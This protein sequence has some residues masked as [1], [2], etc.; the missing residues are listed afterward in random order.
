MD[1]N[2]I[3]NALYDL[4]FTAS[5]NMRYYALLR[6]TYTHL[7]QTWFMVGVGVALLAAIVLL[8][9]RRRGYGVIDTIGVVGIVLV[10]VCVY[11]TAYYAN[12]ADMTSPHYR[13]WQ[14]HYHDVEQVYFRARIAD[15][16]TQMDSIEYMLKLLHEGELLQHAADGIATDTDLLLQA[17]NDELQARTGFKSYEEMVAAGYP[18]PHPREEESAP[19]E[20]ELELPGG[21]ELFIIPPGQEWE[22]VA[23]PAPAEED[24]IT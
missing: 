16:P 24:L 21:L 6:A 10:I 14:T 8:F 17:Y 1:G 12:A 2:A 23:P 15:D 22:P 19:K 13:R 18:G 5:M 7:T 11:V 3:L 9:C 4:S 20:E